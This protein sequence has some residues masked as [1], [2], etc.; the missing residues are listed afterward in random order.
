MKSWESLAN[1][2]A[3]RPAII[4]GKGPS[5]DA[6]LAHGCP[7][8]DNA[9]IIGI[10]DVTAT[11]PATL[12]VPWSVSTHRYEQWKDLPTQWVISIPA[13]QS[14]PLVWNKEE[15]TAPAWAAHNFLHMIGLQVAADLTREDLA[16]THILANHS[17]SAQ[18]AIHFAWY[19]GCTSCTLVGID[20]PGPQGQHYGPARHGAYLKPPHPG[21]QTYTGMKLDTERLCNI[22]FDT[23][24]SHWGTP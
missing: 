23:R 10:N 16:S 7:H 3:A 2:A 18:P 12:H 19:L 5:L 20:G 17:S 9:V 22:L 8:P 13:T 1:S 14:S 11:L 6:W 15:W 4:L 21:L 24:W